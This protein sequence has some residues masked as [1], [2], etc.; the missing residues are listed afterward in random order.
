MESS[1]LRRYPRGHRMKH[2]LCIFLIIAAALLVFAPAAMF[3]FVRW[4]D[5]QLITGN[6]Y[7]VPPTLAGAL[8]AWQGAYRHLYI[9]LTYNVW[10]LLASAGDPGGAQGAPNPYLFHTANIAL[11]I[12]S[13]LLLYGLARKVVPWVW[14]AAACAIL[15]AVHPL[16]VE[17]VA[18]AT[19]MKDVLSGF[20]AMLALY[21]YVRAATAPAGRPRGRLHGWW[22]GLAAL[23]L[24]L[25]SLA[26]PGVMT[27]PLVALAIDVGL[28][29]RPWKRAF[30]CTMPMA[31]A[32]IPSVVVT[33]LVQ[34][35]GALHLCEFWQ[36]PFIAG[37]AL[38]TYLLK[39]VWPATLTIDYGL[40]PQYVLQGRW[41]WFAWLVPM[42]AAVLAWAYR[43]L[44]RQL[45]SALA[46]FVF[47]LAPVL[48]FMPFLFQ[49]YST[50]A[51]R[52]VYL[53]MIGPALALAYMLA[54]LPRRYAAAGGIVILTA[55]AIRSMVQVQTWRDTDTLLENTIAAN[56]RSYLAHTNSAAELVNHGVGLLTGAQNPSDAAAGRAMMAA[57]EAHLKRALEIWPDFPAAWDALSIYYLKTG[58]VDEAL[59]A[60]QKAADAFDRLPPALTE[61]LRMRVALAQACL[62]NGRREQ[63]IANLEAF[64][65]RNPGDAEATA[66][67][68]QA[69]TSPTGN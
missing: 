25:A 23:C 24:A 4:D 69:T 26:K 27:V 33:W 35:T 36:R 60:R 66:L 3:E 14:P 41:I 6:P 7:V 15:W 39:L 21:I 18:W 44:R 29:K 53:A 46:I 20:L 51:D 63:A 58:R 8:A 17:A 10:A 12:G 67:L 48:G 40:S 65:K 64:L 22:Y 32:V 47:V 45:I 9:P 1:C 37:H 55:L 19:G 38:A 43:P 30:A 61:G 11:H 50:V 13:A 68:Q 62:K 57:G 42:G 49:F 16:Q 56:S 31:A 59:D 54:Q 2:R 5:N 52:Y 34:P 28:Q